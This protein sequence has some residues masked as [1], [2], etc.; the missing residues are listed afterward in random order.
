MESNPH[1]LNPVILRLAQS[2]WRFKLYLLWKLPAGWFM[3]MRIGSLTS[4]QC[5]TL[6]PYRWRSQNPFRSTYFA[7][8]CATGELSTGLLCLAAI[9]ATQKVS[10]LVVSIQAQF[11]KKADKTL[12][13]TCNEGQKVRET[14]Q[15]AIDTGEGQTLE[16]VSTGTLPDGTIASEIRIFWSF[17]KSNK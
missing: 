11:F 15:K 6:L 4:E 1:N 8:Q 16:M 17:K 3:G 12:T 5:T 9:P 10:M 2:P 14:I 13:F 7:A